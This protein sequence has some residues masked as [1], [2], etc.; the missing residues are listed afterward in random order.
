MSAKTK[1]KVRSLAGGRQ[2]T[3][4]LFM[5]QET[6]D[7]YAVRPEPVPPQELPR[8]ETTASKAVEEFGVPEKVP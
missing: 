5:R 6:L 1:K 3:L 4:D 2:L 8:A 7:K